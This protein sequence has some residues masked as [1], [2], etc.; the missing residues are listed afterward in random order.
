MVNHLKS[1][2]NNALIRLKVQC[3]SKISG[4]GHLVAV[5]MVLAVVCV[6]VL[7]FKDEITVW[8]VDVFANYKSETTKIFS[9]M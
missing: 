8:F 2:I 4:E 5:L 6:L 7:Y 9:N 1:K 3:E